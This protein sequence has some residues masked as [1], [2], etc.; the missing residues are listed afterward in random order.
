MAS[1]W[2]TGLFF[3]A[4]QKISMIKISIAKY[5]SIR[6][7]T[8][9]LLITSAFPYIQIVPN[10][11]YTQPLP[12][13]FGAILFL[14]NLEQLSKLKHLDRIVII[15]IAILGALLFALTCTPYNNYQE[16]K[17]L[18]TYLCPLLLVPSFLAA[19]Y[20]MPYLTMIILR[21]AIVI[22]LLTGFIQTYID[23]TFGL[24]L[25]GIWGN[26]A[27]DIIDSGR[28]VL[29]L[30]PEPTHHAFQILLLGACLA[31]LDNT[32]IG[33]FL[34][35]GCIISAVLF[36]ASSSALLVLLVACIT[37][38]LHR[39]LLLALIFVL[40][41]SFTWEMFPYIVKEFFGLNSRIT[42]LLS[43][44]LEN[45]STFLMTDK[46]ANIRLGGLWS[47]FSHTLESGF[48][49][50]GLSQEAWLHARDGMLLKYHWL[51][52]LSLIGP[53]SGLGV[54]IFQAGLLILPF[55]IISMHRIVSHTTDTM[56]GQ[57]LIYCV[58]LIF[59][60]QFY[61]STPVFSLIYA[62]AAYNYAK[63]HTP[64]QQAHNS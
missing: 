17:Y 45:P 44:F 1:G 30:A 40:I 52:T 27:Q 18:L 39:K 41:V 11:S 61:L 22:W 54:L 6:I 50:H 33:L 9:F 51:I 55:I 2:H 4:T 62:C 37:Y 21:C 23:S 10:A 36:A 49:P 20:N 25:L 46:S 38:F 58:P 19:I 5:I 57:I 60:N 53:A 32:R 28:G 8:V 14:F 64:S 15:S 3:R 26:A 31:Y 43:N 7:L 63:R 12:L 29:G 16:F 13:L 34:G 48:M 56:T 42:I 59:L 24:S 35:I 47:I